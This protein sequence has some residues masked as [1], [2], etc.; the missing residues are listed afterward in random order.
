MPEK[1]YQR[2]VYK[3][4]QQQGGGRGGEDIMANDPKVQEIMRMQLPEKQSQ[5]EGTFFKD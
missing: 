2:Q 1:K 3:D 4:R 5:V